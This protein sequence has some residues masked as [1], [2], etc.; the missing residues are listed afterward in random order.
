MSAFLQAL[1]VEESQDGV[2][3]K[4]ALHTQGAGAV[5][6]EHIWVVTLSYG[7]APSISGAK[8]LT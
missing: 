5:G 3:G 2:G 7:G 4:D 8:R 1:G 6:R